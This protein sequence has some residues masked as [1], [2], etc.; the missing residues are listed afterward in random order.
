MISSSEISS[1]TQMFEENGKYE[2]IEFLLI[3]LPEWRVQFN[4]D[5]IVIELLRLINSNKSIYS[6]PEFLL[7][8]D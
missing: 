2:A 8:L 1:S 7:L 4:L 6:I 5:A 3:D